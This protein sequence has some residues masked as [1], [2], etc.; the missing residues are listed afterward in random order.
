MQVEAG[1]LLVLAADRSVLDCCE[2]LGRVRTFAAHVMQAQRLLTLDPTQFNFLWV[3]DFPLFTLEDGQLT[4]TH[5]PFTAPIDEHKKLL[6][7][8]YTTDLLRI[9]AQHYDVVVNGI[10]MGGGSIRNHERQV[11]RRIFQIL[12]SE[13]S[14]LWHDFSHLLDGLSYGCPPHGGLA[15]GFDRL[16]MLLSGANNLRD[17]IAFPKTAA[18]NELMTGSPATISSKELEEFGLKY[19]AEEENKKE[20][21]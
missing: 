10:E 12:E 16:V 8:D 7:S 4:S 2:V 15:I 14:N 19:S 6:A 11:Q 21:K 17:V 13:T 5:H 20:N 3:V 1:D 18:G 9:R